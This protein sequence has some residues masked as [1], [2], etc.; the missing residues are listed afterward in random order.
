MKGGWRGWG[1]G[2]GTQ[3]LVLEYA[4]AGRGRGWWWC[5][6]AVVVGSL[7]VVLGVL[8]ACCRLGVVSGVGGWGLGVGGVEASGGRVCVYR[9]ACLFGSL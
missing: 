1:G 8:E 9:E 2:G 5:M 6:W 7:G 3:Q 4:D